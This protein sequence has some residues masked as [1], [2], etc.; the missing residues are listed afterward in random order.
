VGDDAVGV[1]LE[2]RIGSR[3]GAR[4]RIALEPFVFVDY[5][6]AVIDDNRLVPDPRDVLTAG[7]GVR[8]R[9]SDRIDFA[10]TFAAPLQRAGYQAGRSDPRVLFTVATRLLPWGDH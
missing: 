4:G 3:S 1:S 5:A 8:G 7:A 9:W 10:L 2:A 6:H